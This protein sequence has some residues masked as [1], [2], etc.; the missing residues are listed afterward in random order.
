MKTVL[1]TLAVLG[2]GLSAAHACPMHS[3]GAHDTMTTASI[4]ADTVPMSTR[5]DSLEGAGDE[6]AVLGDKASDAVVEEDKA[7]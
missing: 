1:A 5:G 7:D 3:A 6:A 2:L 4:A